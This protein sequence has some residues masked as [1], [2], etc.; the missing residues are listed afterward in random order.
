RIPDLHPAG[1]REVVFNEALPTAARY[2]AWKG[3]TAFLARDGRIIPVSQVILAH[4]SKDG[5][6]EYFSTVARDV[7]DRRRSEQQL[8]YLASHDFLTGLLNRARFQERLAQTLCRC[9]CPSGRGALLFLDLD[10]FKDINDSLEIGRAH[11]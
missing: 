3:E 10:N 11:V 6:V 9:E 5:T 7:S 2:G 8:A 1:A 4:R